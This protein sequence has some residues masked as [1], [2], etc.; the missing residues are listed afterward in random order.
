MKLVRVGDPGH[1]RPGVLV[2]DDTYVD[3]SD[4]VEDFN[5]DFFASAGL[6]RV[7]DLVAHR[8]SVQE[9]QSLAGKRLG[10]PISRPHQIVCVGLNYIE[11]ASESKMEVPSEPILFSKAPNSM[12][13]PNDPIWMPPDGEKLDYEVELGVVIGKR[14][15]YL[16]SPDKAL[17]VIAGYVLVN[18][19]S[20]RAFQLERGS[21]WLKGKSCESFNPCGPYLVTPDEFD[22]ID[23]KRLILDVNGERRQDGTTSWMIFDIPTIIHYVSQFMVLEP[24]DL[25]NTGTPPGVAL[26]METPVYLEVG[27]VVEAQISGL[28]VQRTTVRAAQA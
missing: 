27:D 23:Q 15:R 11:H 10:S 9:V 26:G 1:E 20:E 24:G 17:D 4:V 7:A 25:I 13:G 5:E 6:E 14:S 19:V 16:S 18:D 22:N 21:Q 3:L 12:T 2:D 8:I 28:G